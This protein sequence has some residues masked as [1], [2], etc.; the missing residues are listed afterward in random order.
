MSDVTPSHV[1][2]GRTPW[3][4]QLQLRLFPPT[5][6][7]E[8]V[9]VPTLSYSARRIEA[10][11]RWR[12]FQRD[13]AQRRLQVLC[14][15]LD[16]HLDDPVRVST[17]EPGVRKVTV[18]DGLVFSVDANRREVSCAYQLS[19]ETHPGD[20]IFE[21]GHPLISPRWLVPVIANLDLF[22]YRQGDIL[23][24]ASEGV[25]LRDWLA[26]TA[27]RL[28]RRDLDFRALRRRLP[29]LLAIPREIVSIAL[30]CRTRPVGPLIDSRSINDVWRNEKAFRLVARENPQL[31]PLL[32]AFVSRIP[33]GE[34][35]HA[36]D[37]IQ[38]VKEAFRKRGV[39]DAAWRYLTKHG[40]RIFRI[41]WEVTGKQCPLEVAIRYLDALDDAGLPPPPPPSI[42]RVLLH[43]YN[44]HV[45][46]STITLEQYFQVM[47]DPVALR[48]GLLEADRRRRQGTL[49]GFAEE[50]LG[51]CWWSR[52]VPEL[53]DDNQ[54]KAGWSWFVRRWQE[55]ERYRAKLH[56]SANRHW[57]T[58][59]D[60][61]ADE[62]V[63]VTPL[64]SSEAL[65]REAMAMRN[66]L[67]DYVDRCENGEVEVYSVRDATTGR[68]LGCVGVK[69]DEF[70]YP[71][72]ADV[73]GFANTPPKGQVRRAADEI[74]RRLQYVD[75][76]R[77]LLRSRS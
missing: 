71:M 62:F 77:A 58:R 52:H 20:W 17:A 47:I 23:F 35:V 61:F 8:P 25:E 5:P 48:A 43:G 56:A 59:L 19:G 40:A 12:G 22:G 55:D 2:F 50:F 68:R 14:E 41:P 63:Q 53:L 29:A 33:E 37:P 36:K 42:Q 38:T 34:T 69:F 44:Q 57:R 66:C 64:W 13:E 15:W 30:A 28:L 51:V 49:E 11:G 24:D 6:G 9:P 54:V 21:V 45:N 72:I 74:F 75:R 16:E 32:L 73:K 46:G 26:G 4:R 67:E 18:L 76:D 1:S 7:D 27:Y 3:R 39:S 10:E 65:I 60:E 31:L 70:D